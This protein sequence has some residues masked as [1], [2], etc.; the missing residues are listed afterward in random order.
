MFALILITQV[1]GCE[2]TSDESTLQTSVASE[3]LERGRA[4][5]RKIDDGAKLERSEIGSLSATLSRTSEYDK[6]I[7]LF[8]KLTRDDRYT[9]ELDDLYFHL[10][11]FYYAKAE[12]TNDGQQRAES[13]RRSEHYLGRGF[14]ATHE[15]AMALYKR[16]KAY[17]GMGCFTKAIA[18]MREAINLASTKDLVDYG[19]GIFL[20]KREFIRIVEGDIGRLEKFPDR[21]KMQ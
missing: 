3:M 6:G 21:C 19:D 15:K 9:D 18:D 14:E 1:F 5:I 13:L 17:W 10:S 11:L 16:A 20:A 12:S 8:E 2:K 4:L 7:A